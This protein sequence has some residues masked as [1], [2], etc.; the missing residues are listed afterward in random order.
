MIKVTFHA[1]GM[2]FRKRS[3]RGPPP[4]R[5]EQRCQH[6]QDP[7]KPSRGTQQTHCARKKTSPSSKP[8][9]SVPFTR[10]TAYMYIYAH[11]HIDE[12]RWTLSMYSSIH[13]PTPNYYRW[14]YRNGTCCPSLPA[15][16]AQTSSEKQPWGHGSLSKKRENSLLQG[17]QMQRLL[18][19]TRCAFAR[20]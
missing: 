10:T 8:A 4:A 12:Y 15:E 3:H 6:C 5:G 19:K 13:P 18:L 7:P 16:P 17:S 20:H 11:T 1:L 2:L 14:E 9:T